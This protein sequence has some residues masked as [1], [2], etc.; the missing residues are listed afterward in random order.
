MILSDTAKK[1]PNRRSGVRLALEDQDGEN[2]LIVSEL[3]AHRTAKHRVVGKSSAE[4]GG[5]M[6]EE[7]GTVM[8]QPWR[9][10]D[11]KEQ[12]RQEGRQEE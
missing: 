12:R 9:G 5:Q 10:L 8:T 6:A 1:R 7:N 4:Y 11:H 3:K 2:C